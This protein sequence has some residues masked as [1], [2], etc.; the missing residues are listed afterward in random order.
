[1][2]DAKNW[3]ANKLG[4]G[5]TR[6]YDS[7]GKW[8]GWQNKAGDKVYWGHGDWGKG[9][10]KSTFPHLNYDINGTSGHLFIRDKIINRGQW[11]EFSDFFD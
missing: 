7:S 11:D 9:V 2:N 3:A 6:M 5:K 4:L 1:M 8:I 10:G